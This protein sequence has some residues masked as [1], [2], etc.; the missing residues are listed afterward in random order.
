[1]NRPATGQG[2]DDEVH[3]QQRDERARDHRPECEK[4]DEA[5]EDAEN[6]DEQ[7]ADRPFPQKVGDRRGAC[8]RQ[9]QKP[10]CGPLPPDRQ[11]FESV[12]DHRTC[13]DGTHER[14][15]ESRQRID[16]WCN[17]FKW[18][19][20][21]SSAATHFRQPPAQADEEKSPVLQKLRRLPF[22]RVTEELEDPANGKH[23]QRD[24]PEAPDKEGDDEEWKRH[25]DERNAERVT[26]PIERMRMAM[27]V[28]LDP[29]IPRFATEHAS[30]SF[31]A[32]IRAE[33][34]T[35]KRRRCSFP[36]FSPIR[37][38][39]KRFVETS[40]EPWQ[41]R[42]CRGGNLPRPLT[43]PASVPKAVHSQTMQPTL[44]LLST[45]MNPC[46]TI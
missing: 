8:G 30:P 14:D 12:N 39:A 2:R 28:L 43:A 5:R 24:P 33:N 19:S 38:R 1:M 13:E 18:I 20:S 16:H 36:A 17:P 4:S 23:R 45:S 25:R 7:P 35:Q 41:R 22:H 42:G 3:R 9:Y 15:P 31:R 37:L 32:R 34:T 26:E 29:D 40:P 46:S 21:S 44:R 11:T 10:R 6:V 27:P